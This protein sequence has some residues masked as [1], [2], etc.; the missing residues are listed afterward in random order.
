MTKRRSCGA[1][2]RGGKPWT[3][4]AIYKVLAN[5]IYLGEAVHRGVAYLGEH[6]PIID[7][8]AWDKAHAVMAEPAHRRGAATR[9]QVEEAA[10]ELVSDIHPASEVLARHGFN[11]A[12][13]PAWLRLA[14]NPGFQAL[15]ATQ[16]VSNMTYDGQ[17]LVT[18]RLSRPVSASHV[19]L[20]K[21]AKAEL[22]R[23][24]EVFATECRNVFRA[25]L[26]EHAA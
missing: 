13:D 23:G 6:A 14:A 7:Q 3:K 9:A 1:G 16:P 18:R 24:A 21:R 10:R 17:P 5:R 26:A 19:S 22:S 2:P 15:L 8:R 25:R 20:V 4:G 11:G 12:D